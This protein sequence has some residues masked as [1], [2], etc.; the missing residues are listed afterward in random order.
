MEA[1]A[2]VPSGSG[3]RAGRKGMEMSNGPAR[4]AACAL[5]ALLL[6]QAAPAAADPPQLRALTAAYNAS[7]HDLFTTFAA[8]P[9]NIV[10]SPYSIGTAMAMVLAGA[11]GDTAAE[12]ASVLR[13]TLKP[14]AVDAANAGVLATLNGYDK[15]ALPVACPSAAM[16]FNGQECEA[17]LP[18]NRVCAAGYNNGERCVAPGRKAPSAA[19]KAANAL[20]L[21]KAKGDMISPTYAGLL[22]E[23]Y[24]AQV[25]RGAGLDEI[26]RW[27]SR[28][29]E[30]KIDKILDQIDPEAPAV[31]LNAVYFK[32]AWQSSFMRNLTSDADFTSRRARPR[33]SRP[34][35]GSAITRC[36]RGR[37]IARSACLTASRRCPW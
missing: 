36:W 8:S 9:G 5:A 28:Q 21:L 35:T 16:R 27:V 12:M 33:R 24:R 26:N 32:A 7:A 3:Q 29:T 4:R 18:V 2:C 14:A 34:C 25:F 1:A 20:M 17:P 11:R 15:S 22:E 31:I 10:F 13:Q 6:V 37:A 30:G 23:K 19:L